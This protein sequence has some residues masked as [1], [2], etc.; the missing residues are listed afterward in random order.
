[1][2]TIISCILTAVVIISFGCT[3]TQKGAVIGGAVGAG[4]GAVIGHQSGRAAEGAVIGGAVGA[5]SG[6]VIG[7]Q[8]ATK[9]C[10]DCG[11]T[12]TGG[13]TTCPKCGT[14]LKDKQ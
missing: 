9:F 7:E 13:A 6:T 4:A 14:T 11:A 10:P 2:K 3:S 5:A 1:M 8:V 12:Y